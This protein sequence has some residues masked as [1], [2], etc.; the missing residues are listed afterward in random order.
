VKV[1]GSEVADMQRM[2]YKE[3]WHLPL[4]E[5]YNSLWSG[6]MARRGDTRT[7]CLILMRCRKLCSK[8]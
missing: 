3:D 8:C 4:C 1:F 7:S 2:F 6:D 5:N